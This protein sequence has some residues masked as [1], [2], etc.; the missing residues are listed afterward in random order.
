MYKLL[1]IGIFT[2]IDMIMT[3]VEFSAIN[4]SQPQMFVPNTSELH[5]L[6]QTIP[7]TS[8]LYVIKHKT[9]VQFTG[10]YAPWYDWLQSEIYH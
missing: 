2:S 7:C 1:E 10:K 6:I 9:L 4:F 3:I 8:Y 5:R